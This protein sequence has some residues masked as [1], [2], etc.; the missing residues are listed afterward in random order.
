MKLSYNAIKV[1]ENIR[2][3]L[4]ESA[5]SR[6]TYQWHRLFT[7]DKESV[8]D[9]KKRGGLTTKATE[10]I[11]RLEQVLK[12]NRVSCRMI[13]ESTGMLKTIVR[14][15]V[16]DDL[17]NRTPCSCFI[18]RA[19]TNEQWQQQV[20]HAEDLLEMIKKILILFT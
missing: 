5:V 1:Y 3:A 13:V 16:Q 6:A 20:S 9:E 18:L 15:I 2:K 10:N 11:A 4:R 12:K 17:K 7:N 14:C 8:K 19:L